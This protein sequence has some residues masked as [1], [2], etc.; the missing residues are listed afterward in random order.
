[1][2]LNTQ[3]LFYISRIQQCIYLDIRYRRICIRCSWVQYFKNIHSLIVLEYLCYN[4][5][6]KNTN[7]F[8]V[9][10]SIYKLIYLHTTCAKFKYLTTI[11]NQ[12]LRVSIRSYPW[13]STK[14]R[15]ASNIHHMDV[16]KIFKNKSFLDIHT[17]KLVYF[18]QHLETVFCMVQKRIRVVS[19][20]TIIRQTMYW[21]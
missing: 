16:N 3:Y 11:P 6:W 18:G 19:L 10:D 21:N 7:D 13:I 5:Q 15:C 9:V 17:P 12:Q 1:M 4:I 2:K 20:K 14:S 8:F